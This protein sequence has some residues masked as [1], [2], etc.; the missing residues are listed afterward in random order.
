V[1]SYVAEELRTGDLSVAGSEKYADYRVQLLSWEQCEPLVDESMKI[2][3][4]PK[5]ST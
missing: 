2:R 3:V 4:L 1:F 5:S